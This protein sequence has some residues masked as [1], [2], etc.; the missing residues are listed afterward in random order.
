MTLSLKSKVPTPPV[1]ETPAFTEGGYTKGLVGSFVVQADSTKGSNAFQQAIKNLGKRLEAPNAI[2]LERPILSPEEWLD[3]PYYSG[4]LNKEFWPQKRK[5]FIAAAQGDVTEVI[6]TGAIGVGKTE[7]LKALA[8]YDLYRLSCLVNPQEALG[9]GSA[10]TI[11][12]V[13]V[14]LNITKARAKLLDPLRA[15][16]ALTPYFKQHFYFDTRKESILE[17]PKNIIVKAGATGEGAVHSEDVIFLGLSEANFMPVVEN[18]KKK[19]GMEQLDVAADL[20]I[21]TVRRMKS[22]FM[23]G[24]ALPMCRMVL[25]S[26][27]QYPDDFVERRIKDVQ[28]GAIEHKAMIISRSQWEAKAGVRDANG[29]L[30]YCGKTFPVE[31]GTESK[32]S[33]ILLPEEV[34]YATNRVIEVP[35]EFRSEFEKDI[36]GALRDFG[37]EAVLS[38]RPLITNRT[39]LFDCVR[40]EPDWP[41]YTSEHPFSSPS[42]TFHD[43][44][45]MHEHML[46][47]PAT[48]KPRVNP[49][50][51]RTIHIDFGITGDA[52]G[53]AMGH[54]AETIQVFK[55]DDLAKLDLPCTTCAGEKVIECPRCHGSK[56]MVHW[57]QKVK[58]VTCRGSGSVPCTVCAGTGRYGTPVQRPRIYMDLMLQVTP[59]QSGQIQFD[60][61]EALIKKLRNMGYYIPVITADGYESTQF[62]QRQTAHYGTMIAEQLSVDIS[63]DPYYGLRRAIGDTDVNRKPRLTFYAHPVFLR[64]VS[65]VEDRPAKVDHPPKGSKDVADAVCGVVHNCERLELLQH[66]AA[67]SS[68]SVSIFG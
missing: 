56:H 64:E 32:F 61:I 45:V 40:E 28:D 54:V 39:A 60:D 36:E 65:K 41:G 16:I 15:S 62:L 52:L 50:A 66:R 22:R 46:V 9:I 30:Y 29:N 11:A 6:T 49:D 13:L 12:F 31:L 58:C 3:N 55:G 19:R 38:L 37:G 21:A 35:I 17:F 42:T 51:P 27:R 7:I 14:S 47:D 43:G 20:V 59:P 18:S 8:K 67:S 44:V 63:K 5:D 2:M 25:D 24:N 53:F 23:R 1:Y 68:S 10:E 33:R 26:S 48:K 4:N 57:G 34:A